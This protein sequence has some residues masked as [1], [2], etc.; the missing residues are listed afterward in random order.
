MLIAENPFIMP[1]ND[2]WEELVNTA[3]D[4]Y[5]ELVRDINNVQGV[6]TQEIRLCILLVLS[7]RES[8]IAR[9]MKVSIQR[10]TNIKSS[11]NKKLFDDG[12]ARSFYRNLS[13]HYNIYS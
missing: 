8:D 1:T 7:I 10:V 2:E 6:F 11:L 5:P 12:S 13:H 3:S 9:M 4:Y